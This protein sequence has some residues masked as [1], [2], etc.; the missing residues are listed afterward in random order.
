[1]YEGAASNY[2][3][4]G[5][6]VDFNTNGSLVTSTPSMT[7]ALNS[8][9]GSVATSYAKALKYATIWFDPALS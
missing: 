7:S 9:S 8:P 6:L 2:V 3:T 5:R 1:V 4:V